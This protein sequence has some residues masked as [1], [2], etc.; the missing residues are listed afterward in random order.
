M[1]DDPDPDEEIRALREWMNDH[2]LMPPVD[3]LLHDPTQADRIAA[4]ITG[5]S[6]PAPRQ[7]RRR[8]V[9]LAVAAAVLVVVIVVVAQQFVTA[10]PVAAA[11]T[12]R[13]LTYSAD[14]QH[15]DQAPA[16][17]AALTAAAA[18]ADHAEA[19]TGT[20]DVQYVTS[21]GW[22]LSD[23]STSQAAE[24]TE[25]A[26]Y[27]TTTRQWLMPDG[28]LRIDQQRAAALNLDGTI[29]PTAT[30]DTAISSDTAPASSYDP[31]LT[32]TLPRDPATLA[33][34]LTT[35]LSLTGC[36]TMHAQ[37]LVTAIETLSTT[38]VVP[39]DLTAI[40]WRALALEP[41]AKS[42]GTTTDRVGT[43]VRAV[44]LTTAPDTVEVLLI[45]SDTGRLTGTETITLRSDTLH[46]TT[47]SI[48]AFTAIRQ[49]AWVQAAGQV[50]GA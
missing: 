25:Q 5:T 18:R 41:D 19:V 28:S 40:L 38:Y 39:P 32:M 44:A 9:A 24:S 23:S 43:P 8:P 36:D 10:P 17:G 46:I 48:T 35:A 30:P 49:T 4:Q 15:L 14:V 29:R 1:T 11:D 50:P 42:L 2:G 13:M 45:S 47:P 22:L 27:P 12:P 6:R 21:Y 16:A 20:G 34:A 7:V 33:A 3:H 37:C 26:I 31:T